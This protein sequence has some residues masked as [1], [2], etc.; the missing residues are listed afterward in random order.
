MHQSIEC[1]IG[2]AGWPS[3]SRRRGKDEIMLRI[4]IKGPTNLG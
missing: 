3:I 4:T 2:G 1:S